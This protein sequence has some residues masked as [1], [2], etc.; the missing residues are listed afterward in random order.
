MIGACVGTV[1]SGMLSEADKHKLQSTMLNIAKETI[2]NNTLDDLGEYPESISDI[3]SGSK[4]DYMV[5]AGVYNTFGFG[6]ASLIAKA[7]SDKMQCETM[8]MAYDCVG[9][10]IECM[11]YCNGEP[12]SKNPIWGY[13]D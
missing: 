5:M 12:K 11:V 3:H 10:Q 1:F 7:I 6:T 9:Q 8:V 4:G 13:E 2:S